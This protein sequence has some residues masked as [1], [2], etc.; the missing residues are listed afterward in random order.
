MEAA[1]NVNSKSPVVFTGA[2]NQPFIIAGIEIMID[3]DQGLAI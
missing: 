1:L 3:G 2:C